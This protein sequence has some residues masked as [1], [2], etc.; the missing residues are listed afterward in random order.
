MGK[1][2]YRPVPDEEIPTKSEI[3]FTEP[4]SSS[5]TRWPQ[6]ILFLQFGIIVA[7][8]ASLH[9]LANHPPSDIKCAKQLSPYCEMRHHEP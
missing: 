1:S 7:L 4:K 9:I 6:I 8:L 2:G 3:R 5:R